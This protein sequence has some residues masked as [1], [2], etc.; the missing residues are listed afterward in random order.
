MLP[1]T[2]TGFIQRCQHAFKLSALHIVEQ[3]LKPICAGH[4]KLASATITVVCIGFL[5]HI[6]ILFLYK[7]TL[8]NLLQCPT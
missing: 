1:V 5:L 6:Y 3:R 7:L 2:E 8:N 4:E